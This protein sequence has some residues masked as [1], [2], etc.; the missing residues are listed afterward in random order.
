MENKSSGRLFLPVLILFGITVLLTVAGRQKLYDWN[1]DWL[2]LL[3]G[4]IILFVATALSFLLYVKALRTANV[5]VFLRM[6][7]G[8]LLLKMVFCMAA[9]LI[10]V[11]IAGKGVNKFAVFGCFGL[12]VLYTFAEVKILMRLSKQQKNA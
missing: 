6:L 12:Y 9:T 7:Y 5:Q 1:I 8:S 10:Y 2:V 4:N 3:T 11:F